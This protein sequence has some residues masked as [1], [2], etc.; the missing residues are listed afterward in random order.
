MKHLWVEESLGVLWVHHLRL[1]VHEGVLHST[2][3]VHLLVEE[4]L[5]ILWVHHHIWILMGVHD[6]RGIH[7]VWILVLRNCIYITIT[8]EESIGGIFRIIRIHCGEDEDGSLGRMKMW[9]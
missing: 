7:W 3:L 9:V 6:I 1:M 2:L 5:G 4:K 8:K